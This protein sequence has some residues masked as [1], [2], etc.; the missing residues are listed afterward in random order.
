M[1]CE[2][3][4]V[5]FLL[6]EEGPVDYIFVCPF[7]RKVG[8]GFAC[9]FVAFVYSAAL[10]IQTDARGGCQISPGDVSLRGV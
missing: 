7:L 1:G 8:C 6:A 5:L 3:I 4:L 10:S 9:S 2:P